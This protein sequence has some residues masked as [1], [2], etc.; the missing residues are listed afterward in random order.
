LDLGVTTALQ[1][2]PTL[3]L[4]PWGGAWAD[5]TNKRKLL[6]LT[7]ISM[8]SLALAMGLL[9]INGWAQVWQIYLFASM[10]GLVTVVHNPTRQ[11]FVVEMV[12]ED[13][14]PSAVA[15][16]NA[17]FQ[18]GRIVGPSVGGVLITV[19]GSGAVFLL[20]AVSFAA[21]IVALMRMRKDRLNVTE[22]AIR[23]RQKARDGIRYIRT[24][25]DLMLLL[26]M[27]ASLSIF[28]TNIQNHI[29]LM[30]PVFHLGSA[31]YGIAATALAVGAVIGSLLAAW[32]GQ[33]RLRVLTGA[34]VAYAVLEVM[35]GLT[36]GYDWFL[37]VLVLMGVAFPLFS[38]ATNTTVQLATD[39]QMRGRVMGLY[40]MSFRG[41]APIGGVVIGWITDHFGAR[42]SV[43]TGGVIPL[44]LIL[45]VV[46][47][48]AYRRSLVRRTGLAA[49]RQQPDQP[50]ATVITR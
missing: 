44:I 9:A 50:N 7:Q 11:V 33:L 43:V 17:S 10:L 30:I 16:N 36:P 13:D 20:N 12:G 1:L 31:S 38:T 27:T 23:G 41:M 5:R 35:L 26:I 24:Q 15:L 18:L 37:V 21:V 25:P 49:A 46:A 8:G 14:L 42:V 48:F 28:A 34:A 19:I 29:I 3:L 47:I 4:A 2:L 40:A 6:I 22:P 39:P 32:H 45:S